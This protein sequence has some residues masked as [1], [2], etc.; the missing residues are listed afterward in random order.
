MKSREHNVFT[1][2]LFGKKVSVKY[3]RGYRESCKWG[4]KQ[5]RSEYSCVKG[6]CRYP[7]VSRKWTQS[8][9]DSYECGTGLTCRG[10]AFVGNVV[11]ECRWIKGSRSIG[12]SCRDHVACSS[13]LCMKGFCRR[14]YT[15]SFMYKCLHHSECSKEYRCYNRR[16]TWKPYSRSLGRSCKYHVQCKGGPGQGGFTGCFQKKCQKG[17]VICDELAEK[18]KGCPSTCKVNMTLSSEVSS[19]EDGATVINNPDDA[20]DY[21]CPKFFRK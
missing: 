10:L 11:H 7:W 9:D 15:K 8:C 13:K 5:C 21:R 6:R 19:Y 18:F 1:S 4:K 17:S 3:T 2:S 12:Q 16:C 20:F 14:S